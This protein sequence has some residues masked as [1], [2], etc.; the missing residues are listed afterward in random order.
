MKLKN[1]ETMGRGARSTAWKRVNS[2]RIVFEY[3]ME[4]LGK[5]VAY[6]EL[7]GIVN[8]RSRQGATLHS[9]GQLFKPHKEAGYLETESKRIHG[10]MV[11]SWKLAD[12]VE[13]KHF[14]IH[15]NT[16]LETTGE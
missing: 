6:A 9:L 3:L 15:G 5:A 14:Q 13:W 4:N 12:G 11:Y 2:E 1:A 10:Q 7:V 8:A 16:Y